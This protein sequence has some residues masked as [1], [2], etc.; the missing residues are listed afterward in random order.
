MGRG[1][2]ADDRCRTSVPDVYAA[3]DCAETFDGLSGGYVVSAIQP[4]ATEQAACAALNMVGRETRL[5]AVPLI[6]ILDTLGLV[7]ASFGRWEG[8][9][10]GQ[11]AEL[12][13]EARFRY[14]HLEFDGDVLVGANAIGLIDHV[15]VLR[16]L[17]EGKVRLGA[18]KDRLMKEPTRLAEA[19]LATAQ[20]QDA[21]AQP[22]L[23]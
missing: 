22:R 23:H 12:S 18:W 13:D 10:G 21:W 15:G 11:H 17:V 4:N 20:R 5:K 14:L 9:P 16:G 1:V 2:R 19:Y 7:S 3:G 8:V 6:N